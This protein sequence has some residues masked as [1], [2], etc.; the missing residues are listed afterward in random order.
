MTLKIDPEFQAL[1]PPLS[2][3]Q[4]NDLESALRKTGRA[5]DPIRHWCGLIV[6]GHNRFEICERLNLPYDTQAL[7]LPDRAAVKNWMLHYQRGRRN[8]TKDQL[9]ALSIANGQVPPLGSST[10]DIN[11]VLKAIEDGKVD[12]LISGKDTLQLYR[13]RAARER[14]AAEPKPDKHTPRATGVIT[15]EERK[16]A[17]ERRT[18]AE[19]KALVARVIELEAEVNFMHGAP[20]AP[21]VIHTPST[22]PKSGKRIAT[23]M[24]MVSDTHAGESVTLAESLGVNEYNL[25]IFAA[26]MSKMWD[27]MLWLRADMARTTTCDDTYL[28]LN[29]DMVTGD[30]HPELSETNDG[31]MR[32]QCDACYEAVA[33]G[34]LAMADATP[35]TLHVVCIGGNHGRLTH[36][37]QIK[38]GTQHS[39][40][41]IGLYDPLRR[42]IRKGKKGNIVWHI[43]P[44]ERYLF[45]VHGRIVSQQHGTMIR[46]QGGIGGTLVPMTRWATRVKDADLF[47]FGH[48]HEADAYGRIIKNGSLIGESGYTKW[49][50]VEERPPEQ[51]A[52]LIDA[53]AGVRRFER[54]SVFCERDNKRRAARAKGRVR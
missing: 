46:S 34:V 20:D 27:N 48:F 8:L 14:K 16:A 5:I 37:Q 47:L 31:G 44:A 32:D 6:D 24:F 2:E 33:P 42:T 51:V 22:R 50:G 35:G 30:I 38:N 7:D 15:A 54:V 19:H 17:E 36:K 41:H 39:A 4:R 52:F 3:G 12:R 45:D 29:G 10:S 53:D 43:P 23:P 26:R 18:R 40:E 21:P 49:L 28:A 9:L 25:E 13:M 1:I 11:H